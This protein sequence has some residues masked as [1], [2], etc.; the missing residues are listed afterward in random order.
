MAY[1][2]AAADE[3]L[4]SLGPNLLSA[5]LEERLVRYLKTNVVHTSDADAQTLWNDIVTE[6][7]AVAARVAALA[8]S[9]A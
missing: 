3:L 2:R 5:P 6:T 9:F 1:S 7:A 8:A 4:T